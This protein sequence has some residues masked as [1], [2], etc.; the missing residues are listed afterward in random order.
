ME[1]EFWK[2]SQ[3]SFSLPDVVKTYL[4]SYEKPMAKQGKAFPLF[5]Q[6]TWRK[7]VYW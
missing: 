4:D 1:R 2:L 6:S 5:N 7:S 3:P